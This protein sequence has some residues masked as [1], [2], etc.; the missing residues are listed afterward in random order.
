MLD[1]NDAIRT[2]QVREY[3]EWLETHPP[4][5]AVPDLLVDFSLTKVATLS[6]GCL[7]VFL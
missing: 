1:A 4:G 7:T 5:D 2:W 3:L 6:E